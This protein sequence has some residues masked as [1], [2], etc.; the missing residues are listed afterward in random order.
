MANGRLGQTN[1]IANDYANAY[2]AP[3]TVSYVVA[4][5]NIVNRDPNNDAVVKIFITTNPAAP[6]DVDAVEYNAV[7]P[8]NG[9]ILARDC[10]ALSAGESVVVH[11]NNG[12]LS[13]R[14]SGLEE[15]NQ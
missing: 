15:M 10:E 4:D 3:A 7:I 11:S 13:I 2:T 1:S 6:G 5:I 12:N 8:K 9:G 14:V